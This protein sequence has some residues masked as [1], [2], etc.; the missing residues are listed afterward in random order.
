MK[1]DEIIYKE[2]AN[3]DDFY[4]I[5]QGECKLEMKIK[6]KLNHLFL[7]RMGND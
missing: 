4:I 7:L 5:Y 1:R 3:G 2:D 6:G